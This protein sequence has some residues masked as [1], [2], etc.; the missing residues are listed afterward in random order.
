MIRDVEDLAQALVLGLHAVTAREAECS[1]PEGGATLPPTVGFRVETVEGRQFRVQ[2]SATTGEA[3]REGRR[4][5]VRNALQIL[6]DLPR[7][8]LDPDFWILFGAA[9]NR[10]EKAVS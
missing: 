3:P 5:D 7:K 2:V 8:Q 6:K 1:D 9:L 10:L 4:E